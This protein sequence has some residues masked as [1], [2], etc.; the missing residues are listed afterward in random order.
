MKDKRIE[1]LLKG[2]E[3][4][5]LIATKNGT[6]VFGNMPEVLIQF[7]M[8]VKNLRK[9]IPDEVLKSAFEDSFKSI[10]TLLNELLDQLKELTKKR[11]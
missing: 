3:E 10:D 11:K 4:S 6:W 2:S 5:F 1:R 9:N 8:L 7:S